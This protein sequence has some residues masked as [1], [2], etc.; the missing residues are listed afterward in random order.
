MSGNIGVDPGVGWTTPTP[1]LRPTK[2]PMRCSF[3]WVKRSGREAKH[4]PPADAEL[5]AC[6]YTFTSPHVYI[7]WCL[8]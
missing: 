6:R 3:L 2:P 8:L 1:D 4:S 5:S 7:L